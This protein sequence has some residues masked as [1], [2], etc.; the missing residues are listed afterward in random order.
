MDVHVPRKT[1]YSPTY[2]SRPYV[3]SVADTTVTGMEFWF[4]F[5]CYVY[6][7]KKAMSSKCDTTGE[8]NVFK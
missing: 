6:E 5:C 8:K 3:N 2:L 7:N 1:T 4:E